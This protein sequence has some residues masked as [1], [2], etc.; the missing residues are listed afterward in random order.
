[1]E[2]KTKT[3]TIEVNDEQ[4]NILLAAYNFIQKFEDFSAADLRPLLCIW[5]DAR[6]AQ[7][8]RDKDA[9]SSA[10]A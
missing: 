2:S 10:Q 8:F 4:I 3:V 1:M 9:T 6:T 7:Y 5:D